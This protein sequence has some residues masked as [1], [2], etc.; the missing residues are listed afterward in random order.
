MKNIPNILTIIRMILVP[1]FPIVFFSSSV[2]AHL[3]ATIIY[4]VAGLTDFLD[5]FIARKYNLISKVGTVLDPLADKLMLLMV[6][7]CLYLDN[8]LPVWIFI[9]IL[10]KE[11][12]MILSG[13]YM[14]FKKESLVIPSNYYGKTATMLFFI[15]LPIMILVP[16]SIV[17]FILIGIAIFVKVAALVTYTLHYINHHKGH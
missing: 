5:G 16:E 17:S 6:L 15:A 8:T 2:N 10:V 7:F 11:S 3:I 14:Y 1:I 13:V 9:F 12:F 4:V